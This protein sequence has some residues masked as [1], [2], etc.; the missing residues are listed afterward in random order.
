MGSMNSCMAA[1]K[2]RILKDTEANAAY[3]EQASEFAIARE[4]IATRLREDTI[5]V[6]LQTT[7]PTTDPA[8]SSHTP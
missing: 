6:Q 7:S 1:V 4:V 8:P 2:A 5:R 3:A